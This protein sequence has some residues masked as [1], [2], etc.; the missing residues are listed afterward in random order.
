MGLDLWFREDV[1]RI[2]AA[3]HETMK[4]STG[5][6]QRLGGAGAGGSEMAGA[7]QQGFV[8]ALRAVAIGFGLA[9]V[10]KTGG[11]PP[12]RMVRNIETGLPSLDDKNNST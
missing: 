12:K 1:V 4:V 5:A 8:D 7:Y 6:L 11:K 2:L 10:D 3:T 9:A